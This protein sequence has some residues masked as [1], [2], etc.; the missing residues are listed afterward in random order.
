[1]SVRLGLSGLGQEVGVRQPAQDLSAPLEIVAAEG[2]E[3]E[4]ARAADQKLCVKS[5][6]KRRNAI[7]NLSG[8]NAQ[9]PRCCC[10]ASRIG[11]FDEGRDCTQDVHSKV[12]LDAVRGFSSIITKSIMD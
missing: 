9:V 1:M 10:H 11:Y 12:F 6:L 8:R 2:R 5:V 3:I 7:A 4:P